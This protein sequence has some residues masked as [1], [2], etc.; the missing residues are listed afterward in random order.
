MAGVTDNEAHK[1]FEYQQDGIL[2]W[3]SYERD[4]KVVDIQHT[5][6]PPE[7][8]GKGMASALIRGS[9]ELIRAR[10]E[11]VI[12]TCPFVHAYMHKHKETQDLLTEPDWLEK[13]PPKPRDP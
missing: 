7:A 6:V 5:L 4:G 11:K 2:A 10:G 3:S 13:H 8:R 12:P 9:L 1:R